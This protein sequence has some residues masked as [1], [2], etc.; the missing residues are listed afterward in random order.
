MPEIG[1]EI[2]EPNVLFKG[3]LPD[4]KSLTHEKCTSAMGNYILQFEHCVTQIE[5][6][7]AEAEENRT[8]ILDMVVEPLETV[9]AP[10]EM[11]WSLV[12]TLY[13]AGSNLIPGDSFH[14]LHERARHARSLK[15]NSYYIYNALK[16]CDSTRLTEEDQRVVSKFLT[17]GKLNGLDLQGDNKIIFAELSKKLAGEKHKFRT[18]VEV[19][20][21]EFK[22]TITDTNITRD[23]PEDLLNAM[24]RGRDSISTFTGPWDVTLSVYDRFMEYCPDR[25]LR[26]NTWLASRQVASAFSYN[27]ELQNSNTL[28]YIRSLRRDLSKVLGYETFA[29]MSME[30]KMVDSV[31]K[32]E[33]FLTFLLNKAKPAQ[34]R[35]LT[36]LQRFAEERGFDNKIQLWDIPYWQRKQRKSVYN[37]DDIA[38]K[39]YFPLDRVLTGLMDLCSEVFSL[40]FELVHDVSTWHPS[41]TYYRVFEADS[42]KPVAGLYIDPYHREGKPIGASEDGGVHVVCLRPSGRAF[43]SCCPLV[44]VVA[45]FTPPLSDYPSLLSF[46]DVDNLFR[47]FGTALQQ[48]LCTVNYS[49]VSGLSNIEWDAVQV[50]GNVMSLWLNNP[51]IVKRISGHFKTGEP[52]S[53]DA[54]RVQ[55][56]RRHMAGYNLTSEIYLSTLD[57]RLH[58]KKDFWLSIIRE[59]WGNHFPSFPLDRGDS[60][61]CSFTQSISGHLSAAYYTRLWARM[62]AADVYTAFAQPQPNIKSIGTRFRDTFLAFGGSCHPSEVFRRFQGRDPEPDALLKTLGINNEASSSSE[63]S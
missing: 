63:I 62:L 51:E 14:S 20:K 43:A 6:N 23:F 38:L 58:M 54:L 19:A 35:E 52:L 26:W 33:Q 9:G 24:V 34:E 47:K 12:K 15:Y 55:E 8:D 56:V 49:E 18:R 44:A 39:D 61:P 59:E 17:E 48:V 28:E 53:A 60:H 5:N 7:L 1:E 22:H 21:K 50:V 37:W 10:F 42:P 30:T 36:E 3:G 11:T 29:H 31:E 32:V 16:K 45:N 13:L 41:V 57:L 2:T 46:S 25:D 27:A 4:F 40:K